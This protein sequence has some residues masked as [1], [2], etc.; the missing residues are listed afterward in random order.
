VDGDKEQ[1]EEGERKRRTT[2]PQNAHETSEFHKSR[3]MPDLES[4]H[5]AANLGEDGVAAR[6]DEFWQESRRNS[7][8]ERE[9]QRE[10]VC[11]REREKER[12]SNGSSAFGR[13]ELFPCKFHVRRSCC[14]HR[15]Y[16]SPFVMR[17]LRTFCNHP[18]AQPGYSNVIFERFPIC[19]QNVIAIP[20]AS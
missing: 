9:T 15:W 7:E 11:V 16:Q 14:L 12:R 17:N 20:C 10:R 1:V 8:R 3:S 4:M 18:R 5:A 2:F 13:P 6:P 19:L